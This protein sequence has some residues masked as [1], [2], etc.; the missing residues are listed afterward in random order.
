MRASRILIIAAFSTWLLHSCS[1][2]KQLGPDEYLLNKN[3][4]KSDK[5]ELNEGIKSILKQKPNRKILGLFRFHLG[6]YSM[7][8]KGKQTKFKKWVKK[9]IG[10][11]PVILDPTLTVK[12]HS[13]V[14]LYVQNEG[15]FNATVTD[16][17]EYKKRKKAKVIYTIKS[18]DPYIV[19]NIKYNISDKNIEHVLLFD[20]SLIKIKPGHRFRA[21]DFQEERERFTNQ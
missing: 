2:V 9:T 10:E 16:S 18:G 12:S 5:K 20:T 8:N 3:I 17:T 15:Y 14:L 21:S 6:V 1:P 13:Q 4:I 11:E 7:A 19:R